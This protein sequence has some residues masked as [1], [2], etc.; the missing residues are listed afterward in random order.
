LVIDINSQISQYEKN[1][2]FSNFHSDIKAIAIYL[3]QFHSIKENDIW[4]CKGFTEWTNVKKC[5][6]HFEGHHQP[7]IPGDKLNYLDYYKLTNSKIIKKQIELAKNHGIYGFGIYYYWFSGKRLLEKPLDIYL[8]DKSLN[9]P[10]LL[11]WA[12]ENW[13]R[14]WNG[15]NKDILIKQEYRDKDPEL[16]IKDIKKYLIDKRYIKIENRPV[17]GLYE[18]FYIPQLNKTIKIWREKSIEYGIGNIFILVC[19]SNHKINK[20]QDIKL[21]DGAY[22]FPPR[23]KIKNIRLKYRNTN[24]F[25]YSSLIYKNIYLNNIID[26][27]KLPIYRGSML[28][29]DNCPRK[30]SCNI[31]DHYSPEQFYM[32]NKIIV[33]WTKKNYKKE[34]RFIFINAWNEWGEGSYLEPDDKYGYASINSLSKAL[35]NLSYVKIKNLI[36]MN[37]TSKILVQAN[38][39]KKYLIKDIIKFTN[40]IPVKFDLFIFINSKNVNM[41]I[42][43]Y[44]KNNSKAF[45]FKIRLFPNEENDF[46]PFLEQVASHIKKYRY[47]CHLYTKKSIHFEFFDEW[48]NYLLNNLLGNNNIISEILTEFE[49]NENLGLIYPETFYKVFSKYRK[50]KIDLYT[51]QL[52]ILLN[53]IFKNFKIIK[54]N[55]DFQEVKMFWAKTKAIHQIF[56]KNILKKIQ[57]EKNNLNNTIQH[58]T[59]RIWI[60]TVRL[61]GFYY[62]KI[63]KHI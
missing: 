44:I 45:N 62:K 27:K 47:Y 12:N 49:N 53:E 57:E 1:L 2:D 8:N 52:N 10:F 37:K 25:L 31:F 39:Y 3:P 29:W 23:N 14:Q 60:Y 61:N 43:N 30:R 48:R 41:D 50:N 7:R 26:S 16:F 59:D 40:N 38:M 13:T 21:F 32:I 22:D 28:E 34:N 17:I 51:N 19:L 63:F 6:P 5:K 9:F 58:F 20:I 15:G 18:P 33:E 35:F 11:I 24:I 4:W 55:S 56:K 54:N 46:L 42:E 36:N